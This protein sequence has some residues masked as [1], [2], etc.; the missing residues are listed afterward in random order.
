MKASL[1]M[2]FQEQNL[3]VFSATPPVRRGAFK[4][5]RLAFFKQNLMALPQ[6]KSFAAI[7]FPCFQQTLK[8]I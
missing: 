3:P 4:D 2:G 7:S 8:E 5:P 1:R 6:L